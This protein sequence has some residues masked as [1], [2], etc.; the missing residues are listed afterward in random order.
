MM[1]SVR[2]REKNITRVSFGF[3]GHLLE[4]EMST[5]LKL[6]WQVKFILQKKKKIHVYRC[7]AGKAIA[8]RKRLGG[9]L[10]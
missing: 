1:I 8:P 4:Q 6:E 7:Y 3:I 2:N 9:C 5:D 10:S